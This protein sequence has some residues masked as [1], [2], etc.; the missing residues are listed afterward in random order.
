MSIPGN[1]YP[2]PAAIFAVDLQSNPR[3]PAGKGILGT[4]VVDAAGGCPSFG[5][6]VGRC[7]S[8]LIPFDAFSFL[9]AE[10]GWHDR[11]PNVQEI[12]SR[13]AGFAPMFLP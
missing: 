11:I 13:C 5:Q 12:R 7:F 3:E 6:I 2:A 4:V 8:R 9:F 10:R 1:P